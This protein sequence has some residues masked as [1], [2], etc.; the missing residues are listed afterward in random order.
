[1][2]KLRNNLFLYRDRSV[3][4]GI[5]AIIETCYRETPDGPCIVDPFD[6]KS[7]ADAVRL[8]EA[9]DLDA[10]LTRPNLEKL[11]RAAT[12][13]EFR[14]RLFI[15]GRDDDEGEDKGKGKGKGRPRT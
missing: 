10:R 12:D 3:L 7:P 15:E 11:L 1:M 2:R 6:V 13:K 14:K 5:R 4:P 9:E 8:Q